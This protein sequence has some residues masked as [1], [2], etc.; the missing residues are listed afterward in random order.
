MFA[1]HH[2]LF[3]FLLML[4]EQSVNL[5]MCFVADRMNLR[6]KFLPGSVRILIQQRLN[7][8]VMLLKQR[9]DLLPLFRSQLQIPGKAIKLLVDRLRC[10]DAL[11]LLP[12]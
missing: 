1:L 6:T 8:V 7:P 2:C 3:E 11:K 9:P 5:T 4:R 12:C 10:V